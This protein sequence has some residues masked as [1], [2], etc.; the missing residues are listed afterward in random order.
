MEEDVSHWNQHHELL[1]GLKST[2][3]G[4]LATPTSNVWTTYGGLSRVCYHVEKILKFH[5]LD[6]L[7]DADYWPFIKQ[8]K[9]LDPV[10]GPFIEGIQRMS[11]NPDGKSKGHMWLC[12][13]LHQHNTSSQLKTLLSSP[14]YLTQ[15]YYPDAF[16]C[17]PKYVQA[18]LICLTAIEDNKV[19]LLA[20]ID[21]SLLTLKS[22][23]PESKTCSS[24]PSLAN[25]TS[26]M[27]KTKA[28]KSPPYASPKRARAMLHVSREQA[29]PIPSNEGIKDKAKDKMRFVLDRSGAVS[30]TESPPHS[31]SFYDSINSD[32]LLNFEFGGTS[33]T[34]GNN[35]Q[36]NA[37]SKDICDGTTTK[38]FDSGTLTADKSKSLFKSVSLDNQGSDP[39]AADNTRRATGARAANVNSKPDSQ[40]SAVSQVNSSTS[41][42]H[43]E[44]G[45]SN[46]LHSRN[47]PFKMSHKRCQSDVPFIR[48]DAEEL[49][50]EGGHT[51]NPS[52]YSVDSDTK[53]LRKSGTNYSSHQSLCCPDGTLTHPVPGQSLIS[54][55]TSQDFNTCANLDR[56]NAHFSIS[57]ILIAAIE[58]MKW[59]H[60]ISPRRISDNE[61]GDSDE[62]I[63][64]LKQRIRIRRH[65]RMREKARERPA[66][67]DGRTDNSSD[68]SDGIDDQ[69]IELSFTDRSDNCSLLKHSGLSLSMASLYSDA[70]L[71]QRHTEKSSFNSAADGSNSPQVSA[72]SVAISLLKR[73][74]EKQLPKASDLQWMVSEKDAPQ[75]LLPLPNSYPVS[76]DDEYTDLRNRTR[77]RGNL[78]WA[79]PRFQIIFSIHTVTKRNVV[80]PKQNYRC[81]GCGTRV[82]PAYMKRFRYCEYLGKY[83]CQ[84]CH[85]NATAYIPARILQKWDF[86]KYYVSKYSSDLLTKIF[87]EPF[88]NIEDTNPALYRK[89]KVLDSIKQY[90]QQLMHLATLMKICRH[91][92][93]SIYPAI[94][95]LSG[96]LFREVHTYSI[97]DLLLV[98]S[99]ELLPMLK[100]FVTNGIN[101]VKECEHCPCFGFI[102]E[103]CNNDHDII[104]PFQ[105][106]K[107]TNCPHCKAC[108]HTSC[109][110]PTKC[111]KCAR[112]AIRRKVQQQRSADIEE[113][114]G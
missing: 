88:F 51:R 72:E 39:N 34:K 21:P 41:S 67:S 25:Q 111:P 86:T 108:Y 60:V 83:F 43:V 63:Q 19:T 107:V 87:H 52:V 75:A 101:H 7:D 47:P 84:C 50:K 97:A 38:D 103:L 2:V 9:W 32:P 13:S 78:E 105:L 94:E 73:F 71:L 58:Q 90:R 93:V 109:F 44:H 4:L 96:H 8:V 40:V 24:Y 46:T 48:K 20:D 1:M 98:K 57:E 79:P 106:N 3:E 82:E 74:S 85:T 104:F 11:P 91:A 102:C 22:K 49:Q 100:K 23:D 37:Q 27:E 110:V 28:E 29:I 53:L 36:L 113:E 45:I 62:E 12:Q 92:S 70:D 66:F 14:E 112:I 95:N 42:G 65:E 16:L 18:L 56:E 114:N 54:F 15:Y 5:L 99:G 64:H 55:L 17:N 10:L 76:P 26:T 6:E 59:K 30:P 69:E 81:A 35:V 61:E 89:V 31:F 80:I 33:R 77:L 68:S